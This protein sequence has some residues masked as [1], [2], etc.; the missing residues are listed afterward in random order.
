MEPKIMT[1]ETRIGLLV[2]LGFIVMFGLV[3][4]ELT[5][6]GKPSPLPSNLKDDTAFLAKVTPASDVSPA[7]INP[8]GSPP[9]L[10]PPTPSGGTPLTASSPQSPSPSEPP[11]EPQVVAVVQ[12]TADAPLPAASTPQPPVAAGLPEQAKI[13]P[14]ADVS[15]VAAAAPARTYTVQPKDS[16]IKIARKMYGAD[17]EN[18]YQRIFEANKDKIKDPAVLTAGQELTIPELDAKMSATPAKADKGGGVSQVDLDQLAKN[19]GHDGASPGKSEPA[20]AKAPPSAG[21][22]VYVVQRGDTLSKIARKTLKDDSRAAIMRIV[23]ANK[24]KLSHPDVLPVGLELE[25]PG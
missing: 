20:S 21:K 25:I 1:R 4:T 12:R 13:T 15:P 10:G 6:T 19:L 2:G 16:L 7:V 17:Q 11:E 8:L 9:R 14:A 24:D 3:L 18:E 23:E 5:G 22:T